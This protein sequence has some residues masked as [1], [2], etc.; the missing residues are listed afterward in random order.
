M[1]I[2]IVLL[3]I[4]GFA[5]A[6][7]ISPQAPTAEAPGQQAPPPY[8][9]PA[10]PVSAPVPPPPLPDDFKQGPESVKPPRTGPDLVK[11]RKDAQELADL[12]AQ[13]KAEVD[14]LSKN[15]LPRELPKHLKRIQKLAKT[16]HGEVL[17]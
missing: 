17:P 5:L 2:R 15:V 1:K 7:A 14:G 10:G 8:G 11:A 6:F 4:L 16:L 9:T 3:G 13:V 12:A